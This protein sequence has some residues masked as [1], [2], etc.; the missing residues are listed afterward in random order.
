[1]ANEYFKMCSASLDNHIRHRGSHCEH[2]KVSPCP[3]YKGLNV[4]KDVKHL[5]LLVKLVGI[6][7]YNHFGKYVTLYKK[8]QLFYFQAHTQ[9]KCI[10]MCTTSQV[11]NT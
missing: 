2:N 3:H 11:Q 6:N 5:E 9:H 4:E 1:M 8:T 10:L 7:L